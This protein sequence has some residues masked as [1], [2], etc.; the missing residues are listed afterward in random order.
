[1]PI[2]MQY[3]F[4]SVVSVGLNIIIV[5]IYQDIGL[6]AQVSKLLLEPQTC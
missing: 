4:W 3:I 2:K 1:M 6:L 5:L